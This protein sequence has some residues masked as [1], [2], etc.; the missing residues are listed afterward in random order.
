M[1]LQSAG[2]TNAC[3]KMERVLAF[4]VTQSSITTVLAAANFSTPH[5]LAFILI[6][7]IVYY[8]KYG[9]RETL[10]FLNSFI[11]LF[12]HRGNVSVSTICPFSVACFSSPKEKKKRGG[13]KKK[14]Q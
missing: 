6:P 10:L 8:G 9:V 13:E 4:T 7:A 1:S 14:K 11:S 12:T 3:S 2:K 5:L